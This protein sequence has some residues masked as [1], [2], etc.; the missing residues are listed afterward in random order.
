MSEKPNE[1]I[2]DLVKRD[3]SGWAEFIWNCADGGNYFRFG[4]YCEL[5]RTLDGYAADLSAAQARIAELTAER[6]ALRA[7]AE[8]M[9]FV[10]QIVAENGECWFQLTRDPDDRALYQLYFNDGNKDDPLRYYSIRR[11]IDAARSAS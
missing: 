6:D 5:I 7:D 1:P 4:E 9:D 3:L 10:Q 2:E 11:A 8:R